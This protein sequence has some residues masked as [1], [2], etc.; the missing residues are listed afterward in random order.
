MFQSDESLVSA[1]AFTLPLRSELIYEI[2][3]T[4]PAY[5]LEVANQSG[6][7]LQHV[8]LAPKLGGWRHF[9]LAGLVGFFHNQSSDQSTV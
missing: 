1:M 4:W 5:I 6:Q 9:L 2:C 7:N 3:S 8:A